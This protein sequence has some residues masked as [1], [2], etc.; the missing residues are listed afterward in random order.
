M[1]CF[2]VKKKVNNTTENY[3]NSE[4]KCQNNLYGNLHK[5][6]KKLYNSS[7][8]VDTLLQTKSQYPQNKPSNWNLQFNAI[9][10]PII[11]PEVTSENYLNYTYVNKQSKDGR[12]NMLCPTVNKP[13]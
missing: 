3:Y 2:I 8:E 9:N 10:Q 5:I 6:R 13:I 12:W 7:K 1:K 4:N 11:T